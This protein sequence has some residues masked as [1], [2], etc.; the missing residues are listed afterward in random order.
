MQISRYRPGIAKYLP[1]IST[2]KKALNKKFSAMSQTTFCNGSKVSEK[3]V[4]NNLAGRVFETPD[5][6]SLEGSF[7]SLSCQANLIECVV[8]SRHQQMLIRYKQIQSYITSTCTRDIILYLCVSKLHLP[9]SRL[10]NFIRP[11]CTES[12]ASK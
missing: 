6:D 2:T 3:T 12:I 4:E 10:K 11:I 1:F 9:V 8:H 7:F 5:L